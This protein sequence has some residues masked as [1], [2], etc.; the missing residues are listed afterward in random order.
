MSPILDAERQDLTTK[1]LGTWNLSG[2]LLAQKAQ[3]VAL[4]SSTQQNTVLTI[5]RTTSAVSVLI[6]AMDPDN[7]NKCQ[8]KVAIGHKLG[9]RIKTLG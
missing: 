6:V 7:V 3:T 8:K 1:V 5:L 2:I 9:N 4:L